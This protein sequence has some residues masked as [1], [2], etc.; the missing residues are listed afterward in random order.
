MGD[1]RRRRQL[2]GGVGRGLRSHGHVR[3][4]YVVPFSGIRR[5]TMLSKTGIVTQP[6]HVLNR[7]TRKCLMPAKKGSTFIDP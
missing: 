2:F 4:P 5:G 6:L 1:G 7:N 3:T